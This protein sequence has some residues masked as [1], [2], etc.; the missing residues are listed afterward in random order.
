[1]TVTEQANFTTLPPHASERFNTIRQRELAGCIRQ[2][3]AETVEYFDSFENHDPRLADLVTSITEN[4]TYARFLL[5]N[6]HVWTKSATDTPEEKRQKERHA[7][8]LQGVA[9]SLVDPLDVKNNADDR[10]IDKA[11]L[12]T[13]S[14]VNGMDVHANQR[15]ARFSITLATNHPE[16]NLRLAVTRVKAVNLP[17][18]LRAQ[19]AVELPQG[20]NY[21]LSFGPVPK[22]HNQ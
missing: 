1:M 6:P 15:C 5:E 18:E 21:S 7:K 10:R 9:I 3:V 12:S 20:I 19:S 13:L 17:A 4:A 8:V 2:A 11:I 22:Q 16:A 14:S